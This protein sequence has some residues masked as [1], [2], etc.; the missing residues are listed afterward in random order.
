MG[1]WNMYDFSSSIDYFLQVT[2]TKIYAHDT[3]EMLY[4]PL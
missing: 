3:I 2:L 1:L 4:I